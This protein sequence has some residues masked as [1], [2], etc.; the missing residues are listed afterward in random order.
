MVA[1][2]STGPTARGVQ[3][4]SATTTNLQAGGT[5][6]MGMTGVCASQGKDLPL[7][8]HTKILLDGFQG[9]LMF[10]IVGAKN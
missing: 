7:T 5:D 3:S 9:E 4:N 1:V 6:T 2:F 10:Y 8:T